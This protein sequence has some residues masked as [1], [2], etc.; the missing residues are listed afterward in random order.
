M[1]S[2]R[3][4]SIGCRRGRGTC[5]R[6]R[7]EPTCSPS[8]TPPP[9]RSTP[10]PRPS[11]GSWRPASPRRTRS[12]PGTSCRPGA[13]S[14]GTARS[15]PGRCPTAPPAA[16][17]FR[18]VGAHTDSPNLRIKPQPDTGRA[19]WRQLGVEVYGGALLNSWL[20]RDLGLS[21]R[22]AVRAEAAAS[23]C[24]WSGSTGRSCGSRSSPS[25]STAR[26]TSEGLLLNRQQHLAPVWARRR[27]PS[28]AASPRFLAGELGVE[29]DEVLAWDVMVHDL[30]PGAVPG[31]RPTSC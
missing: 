21:G 14:P 28:P 20:D 18:L 16:A 13:S 29:A 6:G 15:S 9:R 30:T 25:T 10:S 5:G 26:S 23:R 19:G 31:S 4:P 24:A 17:P 27:R 8:S 7:R 12:R 22:V 2:I 1:P 3:A 11:A